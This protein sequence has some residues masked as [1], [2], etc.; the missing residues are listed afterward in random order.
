MASHLG[1][2][3]CYSMSH[4]PRLFCAQQE[5]TIVE[6]MFITGRSHQEFGQHLFLQ[7]KQLINFIF[8]AE[9]IYFVN[10]YKMTA[11][12]FPI[13]IFELWILK[14]RN[15]FQ[16]ENVVQDIYSSDVVELDSKNISLC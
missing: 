7:S 13:L 11:T 12:G 5:A 14:V 10:S 3:F 15:K 2:N 4:H 1:S 8:F 6:R 9:I 16:L